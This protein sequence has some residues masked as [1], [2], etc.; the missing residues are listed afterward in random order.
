[1][2]MKKGV[3]LA[4][5]AVLIVAALLAAGWGRFLERSQRKPPRPAITFTT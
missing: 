3:P 2:I 5:V 1:M 4:I